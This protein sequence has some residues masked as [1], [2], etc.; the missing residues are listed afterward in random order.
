VEV[1]VLEI[2]PTRVK[3]GIEAPAMIVVARKEVLLTAEQNRRAAVFDPGA[4]V[5]AGRWLPPTS[6]KNG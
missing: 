2:T 3:L 5:S 4:L 1:T 6:A